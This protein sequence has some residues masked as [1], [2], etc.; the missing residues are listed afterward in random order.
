MT[1]PKISVITICF[2]D[3]CGLQRTAESIAVQTCRDFEWI[4]IDGGSTDGSRELA[5]GYGILV[6]HL[7]SEPDT[8]IYNAMNKGIKVSKGEF[9]LF[10][11]SGDCLCDENVL[12]KAAP[13]LK[14]KDIYVGLEDLG[15]AVWDF[16]TSTPEQICRQM[17][18]SSFPH[19]STFIR[20]GLFDTCGLYREDKRAVSDWW[21]FFN[22]VILGRASVEKLPMMVSVFAS[23]G[24]SSTQPQLLER[25]R[26]ELL[27]EL[28]GIAF[29][30]K[31]Y[32][33]NYYNVSALNDS[34]F[35]FAVFRLCFY[36]YRKIHR[37]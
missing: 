15:D 10:L 28:P 33:E 19:Q 23:G 26:Q 25:E 37:Q 34:P 20:R 30:M 13:L 11:N 3:R 7:T 16:D 1:A 35:I 5:E 18:T 36:F 12:S 8:G 24:I 27:D 32:R 9:L 14:E 29:L 21:F 22:A 31:F 17:A 4:V 6:S 2:N